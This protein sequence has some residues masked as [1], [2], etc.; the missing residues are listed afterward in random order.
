MCTAQRLAQVGQH[1]LGVK[2]DQVFN[3]GTFQHGHDLPQRLAAIVQ[4]QPHRR[5]PGFQPVAGAL[6]GLRRFGQ[7]GVA[8]CLLQGNEAGASAIRRQTGLLH[9]AGKTRIGPGGFARRLAHGLGL[10]AVRHAPQAK[11]ARNISVDNMSALADAVGLPLRDLLD[12]E[13][14]RDLPG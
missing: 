14:Y 7:G 10:F 2:P 11:G 1:D 12:P 3:A 6:Q 5:Q 13:L 8:Q 4:Q 9:E